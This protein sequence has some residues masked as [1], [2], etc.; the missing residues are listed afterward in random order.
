ME[1]VVDLRMS[2]RRSQDG[3]HARL[4]T[5]VAAF[6]SFVLTLAWPAAR[7]AATTPTVTLTPLGAT[8]LAQG[9]PFSVRASASN[10]DPTSQTANI[11]FTLLSVGSG[12]R[13]VPF[14]RWIVT[15]QGHGTASTVLTF[16]PSQWFEQLGTQRVSASIDGSPVGTPLDVEVTAPTVIV[17]VFEDDTA[18]AGIS[19][20]LPP[21]R[22]WEYGVGA[23]WADVNADGFPDLYVPAQ[24]GPAQLWIND[25]AGHFVDEA[26]D[27]GVDNAGG[28]GMGAV[29]ADY[30]N[31]GDPDLYVVNDGVNR[32]YQNDGTGHFTDVA[33]AAGVADSGAGPS[34]AWGDYDGD[35]YLD[36][37][38]VD[39]ENCRT[40]HQQDKLYHNNGDGTFS[41]VTS[42]LD[43]LKT[44]GPGFQAAWFDYNGD[45]RQDLYL[46][47]DNLPLE[48]HGN[49][50]WRNDGSDGQ[51]GWIFTDVSADS[52]TNWVLSSMGLGI[53]DI[54]RDLD[55]DF[56]IS[57]IGPN[58][59]AR[60]NG[61]GTFTNVGVGAGVARPNQS[62][63]LR[64]TTWGLDFHDFNLDGWEDLYVAAG[65]IG[66]RTP[67][68][69]ELFVADGVDFKFLDLSAPSHAADPGTSRG[70]AFADYDRDGLMDFFVLD[71]RGTGHLYRN[72]TQATG[73]GWLE[74]ALTGTASN[75]DACGAIL[76]ATVGTAK[77]MREKFC[78]STSL[79]SGGDPFVHFGLGAATTIDEL[80]VTWPSGATQVLTGVPANQVLTLTEGS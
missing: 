68:P 36:L 8:S 52:G 65:D 75:R 71:Q 15:I 58:Y 11:L 51:G 7:A 77:I 27:R 4:R 43:P 26:A 2:R 39:Y 48:Q 67:Q 79:A 3:A 50:L 49:F 60:N 53:A 34:A 24:T 25:G 54:D 44:S 22:C 72:V 38:V 19:T 9:L 57:N 33:A 13:P 40:K 14:S 35:G 55:L 69:N 1:N 73:Q 29:F 16:T 20:S 56:A 12:D 47:N 76:V 17:P 78:G 18:S 41:D 70:V 59:L 64:S 31:D 6:S 30:D 80:S 21:P 46:A 74:V 28:I 23:A 45:G 61:D 32:L 5:V 63:D 37:Y 62:A 66:A 42:Y 10:P